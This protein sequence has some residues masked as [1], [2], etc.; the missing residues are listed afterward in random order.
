[1]TSLQ[2]ARDIIRVDE[3]RDRGGQGMLGS[4]FLTES[5]CECRH[6]FLEFIHARRVRKWNC[7]QLGKAGLNRDSIAISVVIDLDAPDSPWPFRRVAESGKPVD[8]DTNVDCQLPGTE[9]P[10]VLVA[11][12]NSDMR[13]YVVRLLAGPYTVEAVSDGFAPLDSVQ[14]S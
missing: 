11:D 5:D 10:L 2:A 7:N 13:R 12:D 3:D 9:K 6:G 14:R 1:M 4:K 8:E